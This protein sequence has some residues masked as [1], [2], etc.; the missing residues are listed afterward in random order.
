[1]GGVKRNRMVTDNIRLLKNGIRDTVME[2][3]G[4]LHNFRIQY[5]PWNDSS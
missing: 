3:C 2:T 4:R 1:M 5:Q